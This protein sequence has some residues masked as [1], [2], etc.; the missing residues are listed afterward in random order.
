M[1]YE[2]TETSTL[3][4]PTDTVPRDYCCDIKTSSE[5]LDIAIETNIHECAHE[6][7]FMNITIPA[8]TI[9]G[10]IL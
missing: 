5:L 10:I 1:D 9:I 4:K 3:S 2:E 6:L 7:R 8:P